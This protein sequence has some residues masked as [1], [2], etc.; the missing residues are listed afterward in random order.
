M[1]RKLLLLL[2][3]ASINIIAQTEYPKVSEANYI[4]IKDHKIYHEL[5]GEGIPVILIHGGYLSSEIWN[6][7]ISFLNKNGFMTIVFDDLGHGKT[8][9]G[10]EEALWV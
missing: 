4:K 7:Q 8:I 9:R 5:S 3:I 1:L 10:N 6:N 2:F